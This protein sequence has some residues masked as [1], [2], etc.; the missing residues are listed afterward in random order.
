[1]D[2]EKV[3]LDALRKAARPMR[4]GEVAEATG[5]PKD[6]VSKIFNQL[7]KADKIIS[8]KRCFYELKS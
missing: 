5:L 8:P 4:A 7:K 6:Q 3:I 2:T 1:M